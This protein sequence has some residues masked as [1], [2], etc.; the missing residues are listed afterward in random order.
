[1]HCC[2]GGDGDFMSIV[3]SSEPASTVCCLRLVHCLGLLLAVAY[4]D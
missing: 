1:M 2:G 3:S 4:L